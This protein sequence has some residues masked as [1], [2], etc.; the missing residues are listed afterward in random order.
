[1]RQTHQ[2][3][4]LFRFFLGHPRFARATLYTPF[5]RVQT[6]KEDPLEEDLLMVSEFSQLLCEI[7]PT[8]STRIAPFSIRKENNI[9]P[10]RSNDNSYSTI[11]LQKKEERRKKTG[12][13][14]RNNSLET[15]QWR[16]GSHGGTI[17]RGQS[18]RN[19][20]DSIIE[21][22]VLVKEKFNRM[23][24]KTI[25]SRMNPSRNRGMLSF[26]KYQFFVAVNLSSPLIIIESNLFYCSKI[27]LSFFFFSF[28]LENKFHKNL[29]VY[30]YIQFKCV[31]IIFEQECSR[32]SRVK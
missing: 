24:I 25:P 9:L 1:M 11:L 31:Y 8:L 28:F 15:Q 5:L 3:R 4:I 32:I 12:E 23:V 16:C 29:R 7:S 10:Q 27:S 30:I 2:S 17:N 26:S 21:T 13:G 14:R 20:R 18:G 19:V 22:F 6:E